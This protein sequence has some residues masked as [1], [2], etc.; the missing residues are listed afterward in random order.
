LYLAMLAALLATPVSGQAEPV[1]AGGAGSEFDRTLLV[2]DSAR[3]IDVT[4]YRH[5]NPVVAGTHRVDVSLN[6]VFVLRETIAFVDPFATGSATPCLT[7][8]LLKRIGVV[9]AEPRT[10]GTACVDLA[11]VHEDASIRFDPATQVL[12]LSM[13]Q[14]ALSRQPRGV[15]APADWDAGVNAA[16]LNY[17]F[18]SFHGTGGSTSSFLGLSAGVNA[19]AWR[20]RQRYALSH[21]RQ[22]TDW[23]SLSAY[24]QRDHQWPDLR[25]GLIPRCQRGIG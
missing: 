11:A 24:A 20:F 17:T 25:L 9:V 6:G 21:N 14:V 7:G 2:G 8:E 12:T 18:S 3:R 19:G 23:N 1:A 4:R 15:T 5:G 13:P 16:L 10:T 22:G